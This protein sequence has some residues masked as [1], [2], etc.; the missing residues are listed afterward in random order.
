MSPKALPTLINCH[1]GVHNLFRSGKPG[2]S[3]ENM[4]HYSTPS[5]T[6]L[7]DCFVFPPDQ[8]PPASSAVVALPVIDMTCSRDEVRCA[9]LDTGKEFGF[10]QAS[11]HKLQTNHIYILA[12]IPPG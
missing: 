5:P 4:I 10:F 7:P 1:A 2:S 11:Q 3:M 6:P 9:I 8:V 12:Y